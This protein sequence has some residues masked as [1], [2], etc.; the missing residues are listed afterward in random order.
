MVHMSNSGPIPFVSKERK[1]EVP[2]EGSNFR[3]QSGTFCSAP[4]HNAFPGATEQREG[5]KNNKQQSISTEVGNNPCE[6][7]MVLK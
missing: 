3:T 6:M 5:E 7:H 2:R 4:E 1:H